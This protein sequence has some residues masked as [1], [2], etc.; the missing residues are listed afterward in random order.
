M[1]ANSLEDLICCDYCPKACHV[2]CHSPELDEVPTGEFKCIKCAES[3][4]STLDQNDVLVSL[5][6]PE[7][8]ALIYDSSWNIQCGKT[9]STQAINEVFDMLK[10]KGGRFFKLQQY[11]AAEYEQVGDQEAWSSECYCLIMFVNSNIYCNKVLTTAISIRA[12]IK[13]DIKKAVRQ[14]RRPTHVKEKQQEENNSSNIDDPEHFHAGILKKVTSVLLVVILCAVAA[15]SSFHPLPKENLSWSFLFRSS[16]ALENVGTVSTN[17]SADDS[18]LPLS[19]TVTDMHADQHSAVP[20]EAMSDKG[21]KREAHY[22]SE[23][24]DGESM[25]KMKTGDIEVSARSET[26][27]A[28]IMV[29]KQYPPESKGGDSHKEEHEIL[30]E[31]YNDHNNGP[32]SQKEDKSGQGSELGELARAIKLFGLCLFAASVIVVVSVIL[33]RRSQRREIAS[34]KKDIALLR[35]SLE[36]LRPNEVASRRRRRTTPRP[37][38]AVDV[39]LTGGRPQCSS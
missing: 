4:K 21:D 30:S 32:S 31:Q 28:A 25:A 36:R 23:R 3:D 35:A 24:I 22:L 12:E 14:G 10:K 27:F 33:D 29:D 2:K 20:T 15:G 16:S 13:H 5:T 9:G 37:I 26:T 6:N 17:S 18:L 11:S 8:K 34:Q 39:D 1:H 7:Y 38:H 19:T